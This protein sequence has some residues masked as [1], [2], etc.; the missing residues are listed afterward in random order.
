M[1]TRTWT[2]ATNGDF[3]TAGN[4][5]EGSVPVSGDDIYFL[6][7]S[8]NLDTNLNQ[9]GVAPGIVQIGTGNTSSTFTGN[10]GVS[11]GNPL[12]LGATTTLIVR[13][14]ANASTPTNGVW[15]KTGNLTRGIFQSD[16]I[17][18]VMSYATT[19]TATDIEHKRG[20]LYVESG[21]VTRMILNAINTG[22]SPDSNALLY[23]VAPTFTALYQ[24][25]GNLSMTGAGTIT[26]LYAH[27][28]SAVHDIQAGTVTRYWLHGGTVRHKTTSTCTK[29]T[30]FAGELD[31]SLDPRA[32]TF[33]DLLLDPDNALATLD[34]GPGNITI[35]NGVKALSG[36]ATQYYGNAAV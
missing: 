25:R 17:L 29:A 20:K 13:L 33:T 14:G 36:Q 5:A 2:G 4:W 26:D 31:C 19:G 22:S 34:N 12:I 10:V 18:Q 35:T 27:S 9:A 16:N 28:S 11:A 23:A 15:I 30:L 21:T 8:V 3:N 24:Q 7:G 1:A 6:S 32:K